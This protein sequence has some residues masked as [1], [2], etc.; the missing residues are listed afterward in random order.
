MGFFLKLL[1]S[2]TRN[3]VCSELYFK[4]GDQ[5]LS[6]HGR[7]KQPHTNKWGIYAI[8]SICAEH[9]MEDGQKL[10]YL[11]GSP[12]LQNSLS[13]MSTLLPSFFFFLL[14]LCVFKIRT[15]AEFLS[16]L[17][18]SPIDYSRIYFQIVMHR[19]GLQLVC[20]SNYIHKVGL[21]NKFY[22]GWVEKPPHSILKVFIQ[23]MSR[24]LTSVLFFHCLYST[25]IQLSY[26]KTAT[27]KR[28]TDKYPYKVFQNDSIIVC[29]YYFISILSRM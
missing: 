15:M 18:E 29:Q 16:P 20:V 21:S 28:E 13:V 10:N 8:I 24:E 3:N 7:N 23:K 22:T 14:V 19:L 25:H 26:L 11:K 9:E 27:K 12:E 17:G 5:I 6:R 2:Q 1:F 4:A